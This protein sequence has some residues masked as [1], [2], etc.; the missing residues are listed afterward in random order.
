MLLSGLQAHYRL[1][2]LQ[3]NRT[4]S[5]LQQYVKIPIRESIGNTG[6]LHLQFGDAFFY[7]NRKS[8]GGVIMKCIKSSCF[9]SYFKLAF[10][11]LVYKNWK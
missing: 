10:G 5:N 3:Q 4:T 1:H 2:R 7:K 11:F 8:S 6:S 9:D